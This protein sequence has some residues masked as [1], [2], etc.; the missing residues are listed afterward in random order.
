MNTKTVSMRVWKVISKQKAVLAILLMLVFMLFFKTNFYTAFNWLDMLRSASIMEIVAFGVSVAVICGGCDLSVGG[1]LSLSGII[2]VTLIN[3][4]WPIWLAFIMSVLTG[5]VIGLVNGFL[6]HQRTE[7]LS[8]PRHGHA[9]QGHRAADDRC[10]P[11][12]EQGA[13]VYGHLQLRAAGIP[14]LIIYMVILFSIFHYVMRYTSFGGTAT[15]SAATTR[16]RSIPGF[17]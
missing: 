17:M 3:G 5:V 8:S 11:C 10:P 14:S 12:D 13:L 9:D 4:G 15:P 1:T 7:P 2:T 16:W 6:V